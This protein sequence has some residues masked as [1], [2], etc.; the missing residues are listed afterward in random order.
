VLHVGDERVAA[1]AEQAEGRLILVAGRHDHPALVGHRQRG[2]RT[3]H[4]DGDDAVLCEGGRIVG[5]VPRPTAVEEGNDGS[6]PLPEGEV[7]ALAAAAVW[8]L[9]MDP[10]RGQPA[11]G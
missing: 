6:C 11:A 2:G 9:G 8:G 10:G 7:F 3:V 1:M 5:R 4:V